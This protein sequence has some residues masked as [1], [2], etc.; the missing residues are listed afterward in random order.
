MAATQSNTGVERVE[1]MLERLEK[2]AFLGAQGMQAPEVYARTHHKPRT[3]PSSAQSTSSAASSRITR[4]TVE[5]EGQP[6]PRRARRSPPRSPIREYTQ[7]VVSERT[8]GPPLELFYPSR[9]AMDFT[10]NSSI[11]RNDSI[12][13]HTVPYD[14][15]PGR[16]V[17]ERGYVNTRTKGPERFHAITIDSLPRHL[18][19]TKPG[20]WKSA[21]ASKQN[22]EGYS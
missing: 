3:R 2:L 8:S 21:Q 19:G 18:A 13:M 15:R 9:N 12:P 16:T 22:G 17:S 20:T 11:K 1:D 14:F 7:R 5:S 10:H 4:A 6:P